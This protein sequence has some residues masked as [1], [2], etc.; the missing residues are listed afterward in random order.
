MHSSLLSLLSSWSRKVGFPRSGLH[1][2]S[3]PLQSW[4]ESERLGSGFVRTVEAKN[5]TRRSSKEVMRLQTAANVSSKRDPR[6]RHF[7]FKSID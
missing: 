7:H 2:R 5:N 3:P 4:D 1:L 6:P